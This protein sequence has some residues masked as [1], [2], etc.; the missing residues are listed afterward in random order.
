LHEE[1]KD[2]VV[3]LRL[4]DAN[5]HP[6]STNFYWLSSRPDVLA[7][8]STWYNTSVKSFADYTALRSMPTAAVTATSRF[9][10]SNGTGTA[11][12]T[13]KN[14]G[15]TIAFFM[16]MQ[17][18]GVVDSVERY[19]KLAISLDSV[20]AFHGTNVYTL[21]EQPDGSTRLESDSRY[22][23]GSGFARFMTPLILWQAKKKML[24]DLAVKDPRGIA[25]IEAAILIEAGRHT[26]FD[27]LILT[28]CSV[29]TQIARGMKR[30]LLTREQVISR[31]EKQMPL[32]QK[33]PFAHYVIDT[34]G[35]KPATLLQ[36]ETVF[37]DLEKLAG[38]EPV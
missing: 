38:A 1:N 19:R 4:I 26:S 16:R 28:A 7:D 36:V 23:F 32:E 2:L 34:D 29:E 24:G 12:V 25:V 8:S 13:L 6:L 27:R 9:S 3:D 5:G 21:T 22:T 35:P 11:R 10:S 31:L 14:P 33:K 15:N 17:I 18:T 37:R 20:E 30:D